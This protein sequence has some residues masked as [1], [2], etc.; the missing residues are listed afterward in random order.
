M[1]VVPGIALAVLR[2]ELLSSPMLAAQVG[3]LG[4]AGLCNVAA[5][6]DRLSTATARWYRWAGLGNVCLG[7]ALPLGFVG[8][9]P[10]LLAVISVGAVSLVALG[11]DMLLFHGEYM[12]SERFDHS[13]S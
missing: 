11:L 9:Q 8:G 10:V 13:Q 7:V 5:A 4:V 12:H 6:T 1:L 2:E 3:L